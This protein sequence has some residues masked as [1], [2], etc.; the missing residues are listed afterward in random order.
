MET[1][2]D[3]FLL[4]LLVVTAIAS[5][6][7]RDLFAV[8][9][10]FGIYSLVSASLFVVMDAVDV[11]FTEASVGAGVATVFML[12]TLA[13]TTHR[14]KAPIAHNPLLPLLVVAIT[15]AALVYGTYDIP[16]YG[17]PA[18]PIHQHVAPRYI[19]DSPHEIG[20]P[21]IVSSV[22]ASYRGYDTLGETT[23]VFTAAIGVLLLIG[24]ARRRRPNKDQRR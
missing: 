13:L 1:L 21:N 17:D 19:Q 8:V 20:I 12:G 24:G 3:I 11:A 18:N 16:R 14:E 2:V 23:V 5:I 7:L 9:M 22:L 10:L 15:G 4:S 6:R